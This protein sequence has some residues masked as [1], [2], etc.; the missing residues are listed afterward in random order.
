MYMI[1]IEQIQQV[2]RRF[3]ER[4]PGLKMYSY[5]ARLSK[6][7]VPSL[8]LRSLHIDLIIIVFSLVDVKFDDVFHLSTVATT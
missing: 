8:E 4:L 6:L 3:T 2:Q 1:D 7:N 5:S